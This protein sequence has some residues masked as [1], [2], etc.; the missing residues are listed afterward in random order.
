MS[1]K[2]RYY[3]PENKTNLSKI[4]YAQNDITRNKTCVYCPTNQCLPETL[5]I[6]KGSQYPH[7]GRAMTTGILVNN[8]KKQTVYPQTL[9]DPEQ[10]AGSECTFSLL[11]PKKEIQKMKTEFT[12]HYGLVN[13]RNVPQSKNDVRILMLSFFKKCF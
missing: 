6:L 1:F 8:K 11:I 10:L 2:M 7:S 5:P 3:S 12:Q 4:T 9:E 13:S